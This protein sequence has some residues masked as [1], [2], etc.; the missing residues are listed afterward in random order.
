MEEEKKKELDRIYEIGFEALENEKSEI[1]IES[2]EK[3]ISNQTYI[4]NNPGVWSALGVAYYLN[5]YKKESS[6]EDKLT[7]LQK[8]KNCGEKTDFQNL[9]NKIKSRLHLISIMKA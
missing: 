7:N 5:S 8:A 9:L 4:T 1:A 2:F 6:I 3:C